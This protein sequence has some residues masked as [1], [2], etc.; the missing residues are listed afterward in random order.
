MAGPILPRKR[1]RG[2]SNSLTCSEE[3]VANGHRKRADRSLTESV[4]RWRKFSLRKKKLGLLV[5]S[6]LLLANDSAK[7][8]VNNKGREFWS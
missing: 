4:E 7:G 3:N 1:R 5:G 2:A 8:R 6:R